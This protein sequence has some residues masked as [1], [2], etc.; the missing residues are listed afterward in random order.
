MLR[1]ANNRIQRNPGPLLLT[2]RP[3]SVQQ[4]DHVL[5]YSLAATFARLVICVVTSAS[6][7]FKFAQVSVDFEGIPSRSG[8]YRSVGVNARGLTDL[9]F[10]LCSSESVRWGNEVDRWVPLRDLQRTSC[11]QPGYILRLRKGLSSGHES[12]SGPALPSRTFG[13]QRYRR[14]WVKT[15]CI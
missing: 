1:D 15:R 5:S 3:V 11:G 8:N 6:R 2:V 14:G 9:G 7:F 4:M 12:D 13:I 10:V